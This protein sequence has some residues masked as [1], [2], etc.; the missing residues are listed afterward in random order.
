MIQCGQTCTF[1]NTSNQPYWRKLIDRLS[2]E[3][4]LVAMLLGF[5]LFAT[6][7]QPARA[8]ELK[9]GL[10]GAVNAIAMARRLPLDAV[11]AE[12]KAADPRLLRA[13]VELL[14]ARETWLVS[15]APPARA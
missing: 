8:A 3:V 14:I 11:V 10:D 12:V 5:G 9:P 15:T 2:P 6:S 1:F 4:P 13:G 7:S